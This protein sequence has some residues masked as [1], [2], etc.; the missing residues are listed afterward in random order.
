MTNEEAIEIFEHNWTRLVN[1]DYT[2]EELNEA[3]TTAIRALE[4]QEPKPKIF[5]TT[6]FTMKPE[7]MEKYRREIVRQMEEGVVLLPNCFELVEDN[8]DLLDKIRAEID[9]A[10]FIDKDTRLCKNANASGLE[11]AMQIIDKYRE[12]IE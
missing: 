10:R 6:S 9:V 1:H 4:D 7:T 8:L 3:L 11:V 2:D 5:K 12:E